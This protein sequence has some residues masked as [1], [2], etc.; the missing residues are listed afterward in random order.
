VAVLD[1]GADYNHADIAPNY[2]GGY[3]FINNDAN[4]MDDHGHGTHVAGTIVAADDNAGVV[5]VAPEADLYALK[6]LGSDGTG[7]GSALLAALQWAVDNHMQVMNVSLG[8]VEDPGETIRQ[9]FEN[10]VAAGIFVVAA[11]GNSGLCDGSGDSVNYPARYDSTVA[12]AAIRNTNLRPCFSSTGNTVELSA[13]GVG[14]NS[15]KRNGGYETRNGTSMAAPHVTGLAALL[16]GAG[17]PDYDGDEDSDVTDLRSILQNTVDDLGSAGR[18][19][20]YGFGLVNVGKAF[21]VLDGATL[22]DPE[23]SDIQGAVSSGLASVTGT[24]ASASEAVFRAPY[25]ITR[26]GASTAYPR[27]TRI[28]RVGGGTFDF[29]AIDVSVVTDGVR[30]D[31][32]GTTVAGAVRIGVTGRK[33]SFSRHV[34]VSIPVGA[35]YDGR[36]LTVASKSE[37][38]TAWT[39]N[40]GTCVVSSGLCSFQTTHA[41]D[42]A[43]GPGTLYV[44][45]RTNLNLDINATIALSCDPSVAMDAIVGTGK[46]DITLSGNK[47][48]DNMAM[49][50][51]KTNN[52]GGYKIEW[53]S[54]STHDATG[55]LKS[56]TNASDTIGGYTLSASSETWSIAPTASEWGAKLGASSEGYGTGDAGG[57]YSYASAGGW[58]TNDGYTDG[59][60]MNVPTTPFQIMQKSTETDVDGE[61]QYLV[62]GAEIGADKLQPTGTYT[63]E[64]TV[65]A[66]TL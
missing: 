22:E 18:D 2:A 42:F 63:Q 56:I 4:P 34:T 35:E 53:N 13:P 26:S 49:C 40:E 64:V 54:S 1:T 6:V 58:G 30:V 24:V 19:T 36:T 28:T 52:T 65:T 25:T 29:S 16:I 50:N 41:T 62:F 59:K 47:A 48:T 23:S 8:S 57:D 45:E 60:W 5:G 38:D 3:D 61:Y 15:T 51:I 9:A 7:T 46:S 33:L 10:V 12:V 39:E 43:A 31:R 17:V 27:N 55:A 32:E 21:A 44:R 11:A 20:S 14:V 37:G 66:T